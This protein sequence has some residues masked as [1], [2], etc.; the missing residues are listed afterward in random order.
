[1]TAFR[2]LLTCEHGG[3]EIPAP[4]RRLFR[5]KD[6]WLRSHQ[7]FDRHA[8]PLARGLSRSLRAPL[9]HAVI[10]RLLVDLN[11]SAH[12]PRVWSAITRALPARERAQILTRHFWPYRRRVERRIRELA[13]QGGL[14]HVAVHTF[15]PR[16]GREVRN[17][18]IGLLYDPRREREAR[19]C[20]AWRSQLK[21]AFPHLRVRM[22]YPYLGRTDGLC[23]ALRGQ[24][25]S[26]RYAGI[27]LEV[28][29][30]WAS[31]ALRRPRDVIPRLACSLLR[32]AAQTLA[33]REAQ[34]GKKERR[35]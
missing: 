17:A 15:T 27:E 19:L 26:S 12:N 5:G 4:Y 20:E 3:N 7:G 31:A 1:M 16:L 18:D 28:N 25:P 8:L 24:L 14:L 22:N 6:R 32:G 30:D 11:R 29:R 34:A 2:I 13:W 33:P 9:L 21:E 23:T 10:S 35:R